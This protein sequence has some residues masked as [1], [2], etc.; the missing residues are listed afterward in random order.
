[1]PMPLGRCDGRYTDEARKAGVEGTVTLALVVQPDGTTSD[2][3][4]VSGLPHGLSDAAAL[5][6]RACRFTPGERKGQP[7][8]VRIN[9]FKIIF[10][11]S[12]D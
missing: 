1:M 12:G 3:T 4:V 9:D 8:A 2:V 6:L 5:A 7:V 10:V 11:L